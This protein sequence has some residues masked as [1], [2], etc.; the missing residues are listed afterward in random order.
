VWIFFWVV[1]CSWER[2]ILSI[3]DRGFNYTCIVSTCYFAS[4]SCESSAFN[5]GFS[6]SLPYIWALW[7]LSF[8]QSM[9]R[10]LILSTVLRAVS[11]LWSLTSCGVS[12]MVWSSK[13]GIHCCSCWIASM[14]CSTWCLIWSFVCGSNPVIEWS[15]L[16]TTYFTL[17]RSARNCSFS[18]C[19]CD[20]SSLR[21]S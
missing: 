17:T 21:F 18:C 12:G 20:F 5:Y 14:S 1:R 19:I 9:A 4:C 13:F 2:F 8:F 10:T 11:S 15:A 16:L 6:M 7:S 3:D